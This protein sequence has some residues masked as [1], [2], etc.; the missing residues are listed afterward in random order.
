MRR[1][2]QHAAARVGVVM[3]GVWRACAGARTGR[4]SLHGKRELFGKQLDGET[5]DLGMDC[6]RCSPDSGCARM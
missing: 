1:A 5:V 3:R 2:R 6:V 4:T